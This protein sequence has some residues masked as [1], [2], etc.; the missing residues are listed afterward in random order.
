MPSYNSA[1]AWHICQPYYDML[2]MW[3]P[4]EER[5]PA[6]ED[7]PRLAKRGSMTAEQRWRHYA[8]A[9]DDMKSLAESYGIHLPMPYLAADWLIDCGTVRQLSDTQH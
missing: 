4:A 8:D 9:M 1:A 3:V 5:G 2:R 7:L 6:W